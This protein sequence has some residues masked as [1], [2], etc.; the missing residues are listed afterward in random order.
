MMKRNKALEKKYGRVTASGKI[1][2]SNKSVYN[3][4][5]RTELLGGNILLDMNEVMYLLAGHRNRSKECCDFAAFCSTHIGNIKN[6]MTEELYQR[7][8]E[9][10]GRASVQKFID[11]LDEI[12][13]IGGMKEDTQDAVDYAREQLVMM[14]AEMD[15]EIA[16]KIESE[17]DSK[18]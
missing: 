15:G 8:S 9:P 18:E 7:Y 2:G 17:A 12:I 14:L 3:K 6:E 4:A 13:E 1:S 11:E 5:I 10:V 16:T